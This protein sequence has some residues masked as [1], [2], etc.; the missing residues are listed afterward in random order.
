MRLSP[1]SRWRGPLLLATK[2]HPHKFKVR[3]T[4]RLALQ[5]S[6]SLS[7]LRTKTGHLSLYPY[8]F[9]CEVR[10]GTS[11]NV[12]SRTGKNYQLTLKSVAVKDRLTKL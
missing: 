9:T 1:V 4:V 11:R 6:E 10:D 2:Q 5:S 3:V 8:C 7:P 12:H